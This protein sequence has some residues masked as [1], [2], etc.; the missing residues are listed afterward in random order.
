M[1]ERSEPTR[2]ELDQM[3]FIQSVIEKAI[4][5]YRTNTEAAIVCGALM[6][7]ARI[8]LE[9]YP[10]GL[11]AELVKASCAFLERRDLDQAERIFQI[12]RRLM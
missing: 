9:L 2:A 5:P 8:L 7:V 4:L 3:N 1:A 6:R 12:P 11:R 10:E